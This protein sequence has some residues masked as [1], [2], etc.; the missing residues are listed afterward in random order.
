MILL[1]SERMEVMPI[2]VFSAKE[3]RT[4]GQGCSD[5]RITGMEHIGG[6]TGQARIDDR[7]SV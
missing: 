2:A 3:N 1:V 6:S 7:C 5:D 4:T